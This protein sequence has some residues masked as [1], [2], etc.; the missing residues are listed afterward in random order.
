MHPE[1]KHKTAFSTPFGHYEFLRMPF[2]LRNAPATFQQ[3][4]DQVLTGIQGTDVFIYL[5]DIV[6]YTPSLEEHELKLERLMKRLRE[7]QLKLQ[8]DKCEFLRPEVVY[9]GHVISE[10]GVRPGNNKLV[11]V[12]EFPRPQNI[13]NV[14]QFLGLA[15]YYGRFIKGFSDIAKPLTSLTKKDAPFNWGEKQQAAFEN[16]REKLCEEP[17]LQYRDFTRPFIVTTDAYG[18]AIGGI[19]SQGELGEDKPIA[20]TSRVLNDAE[21]KCSTY[22]KEAVTILHAVT[23]FRPYLYGRKF[24]LV[25][26][27]KPLVWIHKSKDPT[28]RL[29]RW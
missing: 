20:Y 12:Q 19:L 2:G 8:P 14:R 27:H 25:T 24:K 26:D 5:D 17:V 7:A 18:I 3:L 23:Q 11:A 21:Q 6:I 16:L 9:L 22:E 4:M 29:T 13:K 1:H 28:S 10:E 15:G